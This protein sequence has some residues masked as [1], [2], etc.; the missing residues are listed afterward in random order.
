[1]IISL[2]HITTNSLPEHWSQN[3]TNSINGG[4]INASAE[5]LKDPTKEMIDDRFGMAAAKAT[6]KKKNFNG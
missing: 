5:L 4:K 3:V 6:V 2:I 1:M